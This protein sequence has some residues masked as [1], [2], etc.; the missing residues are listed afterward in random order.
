VSSRCSAPWTCAVAPC[1]PP[2]PSAHGRLRAVGN[3]M[4]QRP[5]GRV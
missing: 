5:L 3:R 2:Q 1:S 4:Y